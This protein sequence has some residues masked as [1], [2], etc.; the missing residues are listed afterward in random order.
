MTST[1]SYFSV[2]H[3]DGYNLP[4]AD[5]AFNGLFS[6]NAFEHV[7]DLGRL[8]AELRRVSSDDAVALIVLPTSTWRL[9]T[10]LAHYPYLV[11]YLVRRRAPTPSAA[12]GPAVPRNRSL[13]HRIRRVLSSGPHGEN[14]SALHELVTFSARHWRKLFTDAGFSVDV[15]S[16]G[17][18]YTGYSLF[19][20]LSLRRRRQIARLM[21][22][23]SKVYVLRR[24]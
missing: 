18:F 4:V 19:E 13:G 9:W 16:T 15:H 22:S 6:S 24:A 14:R 20:G 1:P 23:S 2:E 11:K 3:Y 21:G 5:G 7:P 17:L 8:L 10:S 12:A